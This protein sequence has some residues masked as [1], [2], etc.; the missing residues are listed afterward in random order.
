MILSRRTS[1][2]EYAGKCRVKKH[3]SALGSLRE[4][5]RQEA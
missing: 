1:L 3:V 2:V 5:G 4:F